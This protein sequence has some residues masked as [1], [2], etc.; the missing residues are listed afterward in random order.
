MRLT[1]DIFFRKWYNRTNGNE[2]GR[3]YK[4]VRSKR[5]SVCIK[6]ENDGTVTVKAPFFVSRAYIDAFVRSKEEWITNTRKRIET[7]NADIAQT[8]KLTESELKELVRSAKAYIP[9]RVAFFAP[10]VGVDY[11]KITIRKQRSRWGS[12]SS[13]RNLNFNALLM[14]TPPEVID[15]VVVHELCHR[16]HM[17]HSADFYAEVLRVLPDYRKQNAWLKE[18]GKFLLAK[19]PN[20]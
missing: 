8:R 13:K 5:K 14:L 16:K 20:S 18:N 1:L 15:S 4:I 12:C 11:A 17:N 10:L 9:E 2:D 3:M 7:Q 19:L 6:I